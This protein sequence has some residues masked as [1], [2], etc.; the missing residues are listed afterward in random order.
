MSV[1]SLLSDF[2]YRDP[3]VAQMKAV[4]LSV[5]P[6]A[7]I[8]DVSHDI[9]KFSVHVGAYV[10]ACVAPYFPPKT[11]HVAVVDPGVGTKRRPIIVETRRSFYVG[12]DNGLVMLVAHKEHVVNVYL[13]DNPKYVSSNISNTFHG[14]DIF[15]PVAAYLSKG[16]K[17]SDFGP[18]IQDFV[19]PDFA[20]PCT[21]NGAL[22]GEV[23]YIDD[24]GNIISNIS[25][26]DLKHYGVAEGDCLVVV[27]GDKTLNLQFCSAYGAAPVGSCLAL[28]GSGN[29]LEVAA[30]QGSACKFFGAKIG[31]AFH[32]S[33]K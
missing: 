3:Y 1:V 8:V 32:V 30:N 11:V 5:N 25:A 27:V 19:F 4:V 29:F 31:D 20:K 10:L 23:L 2:G 14:R 18:V 7:C 26:Q 13:I 22:V 24:F 21:K 28:I 33:V 17:P 9:E 15:A 12:P 16:V 6:K